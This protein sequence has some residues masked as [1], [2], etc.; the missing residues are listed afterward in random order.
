M[1]EEEEEEEK[2]E[3]RKTRYFTDDCLHR[4]FSLFVFSICCEKFISTV[5]NNL[6]ISSI[7]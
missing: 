4:A 7:A 1:K 5:A 6:F 3:E 2:E